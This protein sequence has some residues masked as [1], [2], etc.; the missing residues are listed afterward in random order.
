MFTRGTDGLDAIDWRG[1]RTAD[2]FAGEI[3]EALRHL[4]AAD[5]QDDAQRWYWR[6]DNHVILQG[7]LYEAAYAVIPFVVAIVG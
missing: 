4:A 2:G 5:G 6:L 3:P 7:S 1:L